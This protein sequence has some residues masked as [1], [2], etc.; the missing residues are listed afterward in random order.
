MLMTVPTSFQ[1]LLPFLEFGV[2]SIPALLIT[3]AKVSVYHI[4]W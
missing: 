2:W 4:R 1:N 3:E